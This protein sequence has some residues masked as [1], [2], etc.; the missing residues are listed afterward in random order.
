MRKNAVVA[1]TGFEGR[2]KIVQKHC[3]EGMEVV[4]KRDPKNKYDTN[5]VAVFLKVPRI[6][7]LLGSSLIQIGH[8]KANT[9]KSLAKAMD[10]GSEVTG[11]VKS[12]WAPEDRE[13]P[14]VTLEITDEI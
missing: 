13:H 12:F 6:G 5:A 3:R 4:L 9:A 10:S 8:I 11:T 14:R 7:G 2:E 1:G